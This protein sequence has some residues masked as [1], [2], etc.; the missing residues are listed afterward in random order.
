MEYT[1]KLS[2]YELAMLDAA[3]RAC[4]LPLV[5]AVAQAVDLQMTGGKKEEGESLFSAT[6]EEGA[7]VRTAGSPQ[8]TT[9]TKEI[10]NI[11][12]ERK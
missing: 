10:V 1:I 6:L 7:E 12:F 5:A 4:G 9:E 11:R 8:V 2:A 3:C